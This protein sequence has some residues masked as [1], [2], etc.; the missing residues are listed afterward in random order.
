MSVELKSGAGTDLA[1]VEA[2]S[3]ALRVISYMPDGTPETHAELF[4]G[5]CSSF[6]TVGSA[7]V[8]QNILTIENLTGSGRIVYLQGIQLA[9]DTTA[10]LVTVACQVDVSRTT[11][12]P[13]GGTVLTKS[14]LDTALAS[15]ANIIIRGATAS[16]GGGASAITATAAAGYICR[17]FIPRQATAVGQVIN[18]VFIELLPKNITENDTLILRENQAIV[19]QITGTAGSNAATNHYIITIL[20]HEV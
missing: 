10:A 11:A 17:N 12:I 15:N 19:I 9:C 16:D 20:W 4:N 3:K 1:T 14:A 5:V 7:A 18:P 13:S 2:T 8:P 6:R